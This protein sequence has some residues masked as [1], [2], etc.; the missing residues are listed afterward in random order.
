ME[1]NV[2]VPPPVCQVYRRGRSG[3]RQIKDGISVV[4]PTYNYGKYISE[5]LRSVLLQTR[6]PLEV[7][8]V[9]DGSKDDTATVVSMFQNGPIPVR[10]LCQANTGV[11]SARNNGIR[12]ARGE[13]I[14]FLDADDSWHEDKLELQ[15]RCAE[16]IPGLV[17]IGALNASS[18][19][20][21]ARYSGGELFTKFSMRDL[22][23]ASLISSS[24]A[25]ARRELLQK[26]GLFDTKKHFAEDREMW[27]KLSQLG[28][29]ARVNAK[30]WQYR[31]HASQAH[32]DHLSCSR[33]YG[34]MLDQFF[35]E[36]PHLR[37]HLDVAR[38]YFHYDAALSYH[39]VGQR[40]DALYHALAAVL[41]YPL[42]MRQ[43]Y[44]EKRIHRVA[45]LAKC[46]LPDKL[47]ESL[48]AWRRKLRPVAAPVLPPPPSL[49]R[50]GG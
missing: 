26:C 29:V 15:M 42:P 14:A 35:A 43:P 8:V 41:R 24:A 5:A 49:V 32:A 33:L 9:D 31:L 45:L 39:A 27:L 37:R 12:M 22:L 13:W 7:I 6:K 16:E 50:E 34:Q 3:V 48:M 38:S 17:L 47:F 40:R 10:Y 28:G 19:F 2:L 44:A 30:L 1:Y 21:D 20:K 18:R 25:M 11:S 36:H 23:G 46:A 4:I